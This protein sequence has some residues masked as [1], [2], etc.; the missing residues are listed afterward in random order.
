[1]LADVGSL[2]L[3]FMTFLFV[4]DSKRV[5]LLYYTDPIAG[6]RKLPTIDNPV[7]NMTFVDD[8]TVFAVDFPNRDVSIH[9]DGRG[10][11]VGSQMAYL[12]R[13]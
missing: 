1:M 2:G 4:L 11:G 7:A 3:Q 9:Y 12:V 6:P 13:K 5:K 10:V 8:E